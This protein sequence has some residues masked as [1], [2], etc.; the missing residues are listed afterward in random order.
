MIWRGA[1]REQLIAG[2]RFAFTPAQGWQEVI[3]V[4]ECLASLNAETAPEGAV[5][6][7]TSKSDEHFTAGQ[8]QRRLPHGG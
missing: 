5:S 4:D 2:R 8:A 7:P 1:E 3:T 6:L